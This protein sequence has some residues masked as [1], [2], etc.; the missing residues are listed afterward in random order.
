MTPIAV[1]AQPYRL[2]DANDAHEEVRAGIITDAAV[3]TCD[4]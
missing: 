2:D 3:L 4:R 1:H